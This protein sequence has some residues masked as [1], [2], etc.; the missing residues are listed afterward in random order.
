MFA[1]IER[2]DIET[3]L[4]NNSL[5]VSTQSIKR[6]ALSYWLEV[7]TDT[8]RDRLIS[9]H[10]HIT[11]YFFIEAMD[12]RDFKKL[13]AL[14][15]HL[16]KLDPQNVLHTYNKAIYKHSIFDAESRLWSAK[17]NIENCQKDLINQSHYTED[18]VWLLVVFALLHPYVAISPLCN[19]HMALSMES[20]KFSSSG[21]NP[22]LNYSKYANKKSQF[23]K[24]LTEARYS[25]EKF[26]ILQEQYFNKEKSSKIMAAKKS[27][28][29]GFAEQKKHMENINLLFNI[30]NVFAWLP[31]LLTNFDR[32][33]SGKSL[34]LF[35]YVG[36]DYN[37]DVTRSMLDV[38]S[39]SITQTT[40]FQ[41]Q[42]DI[43]PQ[44]ADSSYEAQLKSILDR[45]T[46]INAYS[47]TFSQPLSKDEIECLVKYMASNRTICD[48]SYISF[49]LLTH[50][51]Y[52][53]LNK[54]T[55]RSKILTYTIP[56]IENA[57]QSEDWFKSLEQLK[58]YRHNDETFRYEY[59]INLSSFIKD[60]FTDNES[61]WDFTQEEL[62]PQE[63]KRIG[64]A[65]YLYYAAYA[66]HNAQFCRANNNLLRQPST[67]V[68]TQIQLK[69]RE[70]MLTKINNI[71]E[72]VLA[73]AVLQELKA[74]LSQKSNR[75]ILNNQ[76]SCLIIQLLIGSCIPIKYDYF[77]ALPEASPELLEIFTSM[78]QQNSITS[79]NTAKVFKI[80]AVIIKTIQSTSNS[81][82]TNPDELIDGSTLPMDIKEA[83]L[84]IVH[85]NSSA[86]SMHK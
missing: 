84:N 37:H 12:T 66:I 28:E 80:Y 5:D 35:H 15:P 10:Q 67:E 20:S 46:S 7:T 79:E 83:L 38:Y 34:R 43:P 21:H 11:M 61:K 47:L 58:K 23:D 45:N 4:T 16:Y 85:Q 81:V 50:E 1:K 41:K 56:A 76:S 53:K 3:M 27:A 25:S 26:H 49:E 64:D 74:D 70:T 55:D 73:K 39:H 69:L 44:S 8:N 52:D 19:N 6:A 59:P 2:A 62:T 68:G 33:C 42:N 22:V 36:L 57:L 40:Q 51:K 65:Y 72:F 86:V 14:L 31:L 18:D 9:Q 75:D 32:L 82:P 24:Y 71:T 78:Q 48:I 13:K 30:I 77:D 63:R 54:Y 29:I 60:Y 17:N